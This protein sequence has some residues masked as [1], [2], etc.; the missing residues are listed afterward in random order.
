MDK[1]SLVATS[2]CF[3]PLYYHITVAIEM[4]TFLCQSMDIEIVL[5]V[6]WFF[7]LVGIYGMVMIMHFVL[8]HICNTLNF[9]Q[10][11]VLR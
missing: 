1:N 7:V 6:Q 9:G 10:R 3:G 4:E 11:H 2:Y 8:K 5:C